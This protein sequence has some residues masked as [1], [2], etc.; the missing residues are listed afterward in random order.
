MLSPAR[1]HRSFPEVS[2][3]SPRRFTMSGRRWFRYLAAVSAVACLACGDY[4]GSTSPPERKLAPTIPVRG[5]FSRYILISGVWTCVEE[6]DDGSTPQ[7]EGL[8]S[9]PDS[10]PIEALPLDSIPADSTPPPVNVP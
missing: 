4:T 5:S 1:D 6:C 2:G 7:V 9:K 8:P 10:L 3:L